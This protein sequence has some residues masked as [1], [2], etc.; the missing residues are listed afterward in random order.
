MSRSRQGVEF[1]N[2]GGSAAG[3]R[4]ALPTSPTRSRAARAAFPG[5]VVVEGT[6]MQHGDRHCGW[7]R[8]RSAIAP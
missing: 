1:M 6:A 3:D 8:A 7:W 5:G 4:A 2:P